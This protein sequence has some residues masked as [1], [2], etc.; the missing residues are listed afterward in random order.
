MSMS[1]P[2]ADLLTRL[3]N[4]SR[5]GQETTTV[6]YSSFK[7]NIL[8]VIGEVGFIKNVEVIGEKARKQLVVT[9]RYVGYKDPVITGLKR[10][11]KPGR[12]VYR[13][14]KDLADLKPGMGS[15]LLSTPQGVMTDDQARTAGVGGEVLCQI[16]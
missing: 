14:S 11:S 2:I 5:A 3:R 6:P 13:G 9:L 15:V 8:R 4:A 12:R 1:D 16:W 10:V 7:E